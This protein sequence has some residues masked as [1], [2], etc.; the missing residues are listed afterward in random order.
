MP[1][2]ILIIRTLTTQ[3]LMAYYSPVYMQ[4]HKNLVNYTFVEIVCEANVNKL[5][6]V[7]WIVGITWL[8]TLYGRCLILLISNMSIAGG[9]P[10]HLA[11][12]TT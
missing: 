12:M 2:C 7:D 9:L 3:C 6:L 5:V 8:I 11:P 1:N 4:A 10:L